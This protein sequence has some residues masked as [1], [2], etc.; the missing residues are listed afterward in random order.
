MT[1][2]LFG[3][4]AAIALSLRLRNAW[5]SLEALSRT[6]LPD[7]AF[8]DFAIARNLSLGLPPSIDGVHPTNGYHPLW[9]AL[10]TLVY[11]AFPANDLRTPVHVAL[12]LGALFDIASLFFLHRI[13]RR[14]RL[15]VGATLAT[16]AFALAAG[17]IVNATCGLETPL[18]L[19]LLLAVA[20]RQLA[21]PTTTRD[22]VV[23]GALVG[24]AMLARTDAAIPC[25][26]MTLAVTRKRVR[27]LVIIGG[28]ASLFLLPW[29]V[30]SYR[31][32][33]TVVQSSAIALALV[34]ER[35]PAIWG[36][37][38][39]PW[40][41]RFAR[42][43]SSL[44]ECYADIANFSGLGTHG[45]ALVIGLSVAAVAVARGPRRSLARAQI[46]RIAPFAIGMLVL[47][48]LHAA[49]RKVFRP[50]YTAPYVALAALAVGFSV[51]HLARAARSRIVATVA[52]I[53]LAV[54]LVV[55]GRAWQRDGI[56]D[57]GDYAAI[58]PSPEMHEGHTDCGAV[59]YFSRAGIVNLD[60]VVNESAVRALADGKLLDYLRKERFQRVYATDH[61]HDAIFFGPRYRES[62]RA[63]DIDPR[64]VRLATDDEKNS[65]V[66]LA[67]EPISLGGLRG[68]ELLDD[69]WIWVTE[70][71]A[72][73]WAASLGKRSE[74]LVFLPA[75]LPSPSRIELQLRGV[76]GTQRVEVRLD[77]G[78][79]VTFTLGDAP[80]WN[81]LPL[82]GVAPGRHRISL[83]Y[84]DAQPIR[85]RGQQGWW[86]WWRSLRG[87][88]IRAIEADGI[89]LV[90]ASD[91][92]LPPEGPKL[93]DKASDPLF[94]HGFL[95]V[96]RETKPA[97]VWAVGEAAE[98]GFWSDEAADRALVVTAGPP[99][100]VESQTIT[101][102]LNG[103]PLGKL[104]VKQGPLARQ[105]LRTGSALVVGANKLVFSFARTAAG[106]VPR[107]AYVGAIELE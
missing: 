10:L 53:A 102:T 30:F 34:A 8:Y 107:A 60:G 35:M 79:I 73:G 4:V 59:A 24:L 47:L 90:R 92:K 98:V 23:F 72:R 84:L 99:P 39:V 16:L 70:P 87:N 7:D 103:K 63:L 83:S 32:T 91:V 57:G 19:L 97:G 50:W 52:A 41:L 38:H 49:V 13:A 15:G 96:E 40:S 12:T 43:V 88:A 78:P 31:T 69:G 81:V 80:T 85:L 11:R 37:T 101:V 33:G 14:L 44:G 2:V 5:T 86:S 29:F 94:V 95:P 66:T 26:V 56:Y 28:T 106:D 64:A 18:A 54:V 89:R 74:L 27:P 17:A 58:T 71:P 20:D 36:F 48:V 61:Y 55:D 104:E 68:R 46:A 76:V 82:D 75:P 3:I 1:R 45:L 100:G 51:E 105:V 62:L 6:T 93:E 67:R 77:D 21:K 22:F 9:V 25:A 42:A 65:V